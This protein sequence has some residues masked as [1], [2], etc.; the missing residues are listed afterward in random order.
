M[1]DDQTLT[2]ITTRVLE[3][4]EPVLAAGAARRRA[5]A[6]RHDHQHRGSAG[7]VLS[8]NSGR[9]RRGRA[10]HQRS[11]A[12]VSRRDEPASDR[13]DRVVP[14]RAD[15][16][17]RANISLNEHV[18]PNDIIVTGNTVIDAFLETAQ[19]NDLPQPPRWNE[20]DPARP[21]LLVTA[22]RRENHP[23]H[24]RDVRSDGR[25]RPVALAS[26]DLLAGASLAARSR[27]SRYDVLGSVPAS[28]WSI[29]STTRGWSPRLKHS[30]L[31]HRFGRFAR[32]GTDA[33]K[34]RA[35]H[36]RGNRTARGP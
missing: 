19:R 22:H 30:P 28:C 1:T 35:G 26:A 7:G 14:L 20:L 29:R 25:Y 32:G 8:T 10:A 21:I 36:A 18:D 5:G 9:S 6:R 24:A 11:L 2:Q 27:R 3:G 33:G 31:S 15:A 17:W 23:Y 4:M 13:H 34:A 12:A 16:R